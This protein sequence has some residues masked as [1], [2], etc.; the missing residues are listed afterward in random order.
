MKNSIPMNRPPSAVPHILAIDDEEVMGYL[1]QRIVRHLGYLVEWVTDCETALRL[2]EEK[3]FDVILSDFRMPSMGGEQLYREIAKRD[4][5]LLDRLV[6]VTGD[7]VS[8]RTISFLRK[9]SVRFLSKPFDIQDLQDVIESIVQQ[10][11][12]PSVCT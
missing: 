9:H 8:A 3:R 7:T 11:S 2:L 1:I 12:T 4:E 6:F 10:P 5:R